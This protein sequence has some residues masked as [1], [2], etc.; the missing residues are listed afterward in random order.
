MQ[1]NNLSLGVFQ[2][3]LKSKARPWLPVTVMRQNQPNEA[4]Q[5]ALADNNMYFSYWMPTSYISRVPFLALR[6]MSAIWQFLFS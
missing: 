6:E 2:E 3:Y 1:W 4:F 5:R